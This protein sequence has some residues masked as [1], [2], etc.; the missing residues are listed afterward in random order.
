MDTQNQVLTASQF[1]DDKLRLYSGHSNIRGIPFIGDGFKE[2]QRKALWGM[3]E[4]GENGD[5]DTVERISARSASSTDYAHGVG[6]LEGTIVGMAQ[7]FAGSNNLP[8][9]EAHGQFGNR[10][11]KKPSASRYIKTKLAPIFRQLFRKEDDLIFEQKVSNGLSV[12]PKYFTPILP[13]VLINGAEGMG[14]GHSCY[15]L[16][17]KPDDI[18]NSI[19]KILDGQSIKPNSLIPWW[20]GFN[21]VVSRDLTSGQIVI[22]GKYEVKSGRSPTIVIT[23]LPV[24]IQSDAYKAHLDKLEDKGII[25]DYDNLSDKNGFEFVITVPRATLEKSEEE[26]KKLFKLVSRE[27]ENLT[28]WNGDGVLTRYETVE[29]LLDDFVIWRIDRYEDRRLAMI[30]KVQADMAWA[31]LKIRFIT[32]YLENYKFFR[33]TANKALQAELVNQGFTRHD[34]LLS[35]PMRNLTHDKITE[36]QKDLLDLEKTLNGLKADNAVAMFKKELQ[37][38]KLP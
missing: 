21:G 28:V 13:L 4:R 11:N 10:L 30:N 35:M 20:R 23:E 2:S 33:D 24:G 5:K 29:A 25:S 19:L 32:Y 26:I 9:F 31:G 7:S 14:T 15:I 8:L 1:V 6:S 17:Y 16:S 34:E 36:L 38:L 37:D 27:S 12:E 3:M 18:K 22:E